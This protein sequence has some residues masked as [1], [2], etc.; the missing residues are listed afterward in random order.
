MAT[1]KVLYFK[2]CP[3]AE[4]VFN[5]LQKES[6]PFEIVDQESLPEEHEWN[7]FSSPSIF[8]NE[9]LVYG[10]EA[11]NRGCTYGMPTNEVMSELKELDS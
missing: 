3:N 11:I 8:V 10:Q 4:K 9:K 2:G 1:V 6:I 7:N 5:L